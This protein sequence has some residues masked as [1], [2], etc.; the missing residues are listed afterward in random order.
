MSEVAGR[1]NRQAGRLSQAGPVQRSE[2]GPGAP[3][4]LP[5]TC[6][7]AVLD[8]LQQH[9]EHVWVRLLDLVKQNHAEGAAPAGEGGGGRA[10]AQAEAPSR[11]GRQGAGRSSARRQPSEPTARLSAG[12]AGPAASQPCPPAPPAPHL[13]ASVSLPPSP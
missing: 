8:D 10:R 2:R 12:Q 7:P 3:L 11:S 4:A 9:V 5:P 13:T 6:E 1:V